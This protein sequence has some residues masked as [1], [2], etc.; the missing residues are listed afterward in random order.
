LIIPVA[1]TI[2]WEAGQEARKAMGITEG[3]IR[4]S[5]GLEDETDLIADFDRALA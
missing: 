4:A 2:F 3:L 1:S 5:V